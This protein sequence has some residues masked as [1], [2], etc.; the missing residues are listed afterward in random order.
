[1]Q[2]TPPTLRRIRRPRRP[3]SRRTPCRQHGTAA[4]ATKTQGLLSYCRCPPRR[5]SPSS[6]P[7]APRPSPAPKTLRH[8]KAGEM[9]TTLTPNRHVNTR[10]TFGHESDAFE[11]RRKDEGPPMLVCGLRA[12]VGTKT[13]HAF[14][15]K[16]R[17]LPYT[18]GQ[19]EKQRN[20]E[21]QRQR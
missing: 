16:H 9:K 19:T 1:M 8:G 10:L 15:L 6:A 21:T 11:R 18:G 2:S 7:P 3:P 12:C 5:P 20:I 4:Q 17:A 14:K 13:N